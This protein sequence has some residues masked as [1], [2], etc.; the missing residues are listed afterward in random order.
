MKTNNKEYIQSLKLSYIGQM[1]NGK[2]IVDLAMDDFGVLVFYKT[3]NGSS[4]NYCYLSE[5][6]DKI[7]EKP[8]ANNDKADE[9][10]A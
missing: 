2:E 8:S 3:N 10:A 4:T 6:Q 1:F 5:I 9:V 7:Q